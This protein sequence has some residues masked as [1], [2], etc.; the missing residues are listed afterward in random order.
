MEQGNDLRLTRGSRVAL[1]RQTIV[2]GQTKISGDLVLEMTQKTTHAHISFI[3]RLFSVHSQSIV[4]CAFA[5]FGSSSAIFLSALITGIK[6]LSI[7]GT[8]KKSIKVRRGGGSLQIITLKH[9]SK[10]LNDAY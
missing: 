2:A 5:A 6:V 3:Y 8:W 1:I 9:S 4:T 10:M 7:K